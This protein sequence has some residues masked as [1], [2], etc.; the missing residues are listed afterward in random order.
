MIMS[1][2]GFT[3]IELLAVI[4]V[5]GLISMIAI[6][7]I[8]GLQDGIKRDQML[9]DAKKIISLAKYQ[10]N[11]NY[12]IRIKTSHTFTLATLNV[13]GE[14]GKDPDG[15]NYNTSSSKVKYTRD[16]TTGAVRYCIYLLA[17]KKKIGTSITNCV[18]EDNLYSRS[19]VVDR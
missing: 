17:S 3:L 1:K 15:G 4:A 14:I 12:D 6:P 19:N 18:Y 11:T 5:I 8:V 13:N 16:A 2:K 7:N 9:D 10:V